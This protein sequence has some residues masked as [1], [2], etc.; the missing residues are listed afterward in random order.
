[1]NTP[2][3][4]ILS[5]RLD[6]VHQYHALAT[7]RAAEF[8]LAAVLTGLELYCLRTELGIGQGTRTDIATSD[9]LSEVL[10]ARSWEDFV[11]EE[12]GFTA[13]TARR[14]VAAYE[15]LR[16]HL[17]KLAD[18]LLKLAPARIADPEGN[19]IGDIR[20]TDPTAVRSGISP[21][22]FRKFAEALDD[23]SL[24]ELY[25]RPMKRAKSPATKPEP[26]SKTLERQSTFQFYEST[27]DKWLEQQD[28]KVLSPVQK[29]VLLTKLQK[30]TAELKKELAKVGSL[31]TGRK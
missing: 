17:P 21:E 16:D 3:K 19:L 4:K 9:T 23:W 26:V 12:C 13:R 14:Y 1:M 15:G 28:W 5:I 11:E 6:R 18:Q 30:A 31:T 24:H 22:D 10:K 20:P 25:E 29:T 8:K 27:L 2:A 7:S